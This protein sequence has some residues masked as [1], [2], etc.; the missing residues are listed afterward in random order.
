MS[1]HFADRLLDAVENKNVPACVGLDP[2]IDRLPAGYLASAE[3]SSH[4]SRAQ[5]ADTIR[6]Y[7]IDVL[8]IVAPLVPV[9]KVNIAF[10]EP[11]R[12]PGIDAYHDVVEVA[13]R[14]GLVVIGDIKRADIGH[15][16]SQYALAHLTDPGSAREGGTGHPDAVT[17]NPYLGSDGIDPFAKIAEE[18]DK[19]LF[20]LVQTSNAS[21]E[22]VQGLALADGTHVCSAVGRLVE[23]WACQPSRVGTRGYS[24]IGAVVSPRDLAS[25]DRLRELM[26]H[27]LFLV[28]GFGAQGR[29][30]REIAHCFKSDGSGAIVNASR[31]VIYAHQDPR[32]K[33][34]HG[35][36]WKRCIQHGCQ[37]FVTQLRTALRA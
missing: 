26:P 20:V 2:L 7:C 33:S 35:D 8:D 36:D 6:R 19:G 9:V 11:F 10:F 23:S 25:T 13:K 1:Q 5:Q 27:C 3:S 32:L 29:T 18:R 37:D 17:V 30:A 28:P 31:S 4:A 14:R 21:A 16:T 12:G 22:H 24:C 34:E 15:S